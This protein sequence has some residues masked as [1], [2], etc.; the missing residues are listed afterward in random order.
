MDEN[1]LIVENFFSKGDSI[2]IHDSV[3]R[4]TYA[5]VTG[6][7]AWWHQAITRSSVDLSS[8]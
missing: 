3:T 7:V 6:S 5:Q 2:I 8:F 1:P 4:L